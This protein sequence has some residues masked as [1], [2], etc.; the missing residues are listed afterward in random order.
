[1][2]RALAVLAV[3]L[4]L[5]AMLLPAP[6]W[7]AGSWHGGGGHGASHMSHGGHGGWHGGH[8]GGCCWWWPAAFV[9]GLA[10]G[11]VALATAPL[12]AFAPP[13]APVV[14]APMVVQTPAVYSQQVYA[15][16]VYSATAALPIPPPGSAPVAY[17]PAP[18]AS[19]Q[20]TPGYPPS[21]GPAVQREVI[22]ANG[23]YVLYGDGVRQPW[24]WVWV[25]AAAPPPPPPPPR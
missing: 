3:F 17:A 2:K 13:P 19:Y 1:M 16:P 4:V 9:G 12:W 18:A 11:A 24:Q 22:H 21:Q 10:L 14:A 25:P 6:T 8:G 7:A 15:Q 20:S 23:R 5:F